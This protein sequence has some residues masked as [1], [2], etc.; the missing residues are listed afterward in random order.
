ML[1][2]CI[3][4]FLLQL[5][6]HQICSYCGLLSFDIVHNVYKV[7]KSGDE[8]HAREDR[9]GFG[10]KQDFIPLFF[11]VYVQILWQG[12][13]AVLIIVEFGFFWYLLF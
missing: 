9:R 4:D 7:I 1:L 8:W 5:K 6:S 2:F 12:Q 3:I 11:F 10:T 13:K